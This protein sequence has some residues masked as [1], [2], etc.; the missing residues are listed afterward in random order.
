MISR[1]RIN[2]IHFFASKCEAEHYS[3]K[4]EDPYFQYLGEKDPDFDHQ[5]Q[6]Q[7]DKV[8]C[9]LV[10]TVKKNKEG[11]IQMCLARVDFGEKEVMDFNFYGDAATNILSRPSSYFDELKA[12]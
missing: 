4:F 2:S 8:D 6:V 12:A 10:G 1:N 11:K 7:I 3:D 9:G 5:T